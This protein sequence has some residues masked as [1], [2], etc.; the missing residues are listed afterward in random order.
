MVSSVARP[1][2]TRHDIPE[3]VRTWEPSAPRADLVLVHG[4]A[5][6]S[7]RYERV[8]DQL[9]DSGY[10][11]TAFDLVGFGASGGRRGDIESWTMF[12]D[13]VQDHVEASRSG[14]PV[15]LMGHSMG[16][17]IALEYALSERPRPDLL[18]LSSPFLGGG[19]AWQ[20]ALA[21]VAATIAPRVTMP[22]GLDGAQ[23]S[24]DPAVGEAYFADPLVLTKS[25]NRLGAQLFDAAKRA[26][27]HQSELDIPTFV[28]HGGADTIVP[29]SSSAPLETIDGVTRKLYPKLRH[30]CMNEPE[31]PE[32]VA[33]IIAWIDGHLSRD[34]VNGAPSR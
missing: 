6:H 18:V 12:L 10:R 4:L 14:R 3:L 1:D 9:S 16:G 7:G 23:L 19:Q 27:S 2:S 31:G 26:R 29:A 34:R 15:I 5:E 25:T 28:I 30:E 22:N 21:P 32:V 13:Q 24:R 20:R 8:G 11:V 33:D 17:V